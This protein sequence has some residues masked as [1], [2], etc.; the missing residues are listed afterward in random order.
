MHEAT[1]AAIYLRLKDGGEGAVLAVYV[2]A[3]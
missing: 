2:G 1:G 3:R